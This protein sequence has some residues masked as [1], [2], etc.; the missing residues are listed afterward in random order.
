MRGEH[1]RTIALGLMLCLAALVFSVVLSRAGYLTYLNSDMASEVILARRQF[2]M[3]APVARDWLYSTEIHTV[4]MN[5][6]YALSFLVTDSYQAA[7]IIGNTLG[8]LLGIAC[9]YALCR[10]MKVPRG[11]S[12]AAAALLPLAASALY[13]SNMT[14][15]G[16]YIIHLPFAYGGAA[17]WLRASRKGSGR[18]A[19]AGYLLL[20]ALMGLLSVRYVLCFVCPM[21]V[22]AALETLCRTESPRGMPRFMGVTLAGFAA[23]LLGYAASEVLYPRLFTSGTGAASSFLFNPLDGA[24]LGG[25]L[26]TVAADLLKLLGWRGGAALFSAAGLVNLMAAGVLFFGL[27]LARRAADTL[28]RGEDRTPVRLLQ[29]AFACFAV[30]LFCFVFV[31]G[32]YLNRYLILAVLLFVPAL[33]LCL[34]AERNAWL[35]RGFVLLLAAEVTLS[36]GVL[37][38]ETRRQ[39]GENALR[40][41][42]QAEAGEWLLANG[43]TAGY[44]TFWHIR[45]LEE[46]TGGALTFTGVVP[47][48]TEAGAPCAASLDFIRW[49]EPDDR[50]DMDH[51]PGPTFL[52][53]DREEE[54]Q[55]SGWLAFAG[56][57]RVHENGTFAVYAFE[58]SEALVNAMLL[59]RAKLED[60]V[61]AEGEWRFQAGGRL[62]VPTAWREAGRYEARVRT[63]GIPAADAR[64]A[65]YRGSKFELLAE[66][67]LGEGECRLAFDLPQDDK[68]FML[69][70]TSGSGTM[71]ISD[72]SLEKLE[73]E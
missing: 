23:C 8:F 65:V 43:Y 16:Y 54:R 45:T 44:G 10:Q 73:K 18:R 11:G 63:E 52:L 41:A 67:P 1:R 21:V 60:A 55:L 48:E 20:S 15:G 28:T 12:L 59:G 70:V 34:M 7:R 50:S 17:L 22:V 46:R 62:R 2:E 32:A 33:P 26:L 35:R 72:L 61:Y 58:D 47:V 40:A 66:T 6:L 38:R 49:L 69:L 9:L 68:Y 25:M 51:V 5:L 13:A 71:N 57:E 53:L 19:V 3:R 36:A 42:D 29:Y 4:H 30:N 39:E 37:L 24:A 64:L 27:L 14:I 56:T 31:Q